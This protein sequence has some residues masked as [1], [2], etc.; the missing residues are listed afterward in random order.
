MGL[1]A[2]QEEK[3]GTVFALRKGIPHNHVDLPPLFSIE[4]TRV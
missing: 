2:F 3:G 4:V 1:T